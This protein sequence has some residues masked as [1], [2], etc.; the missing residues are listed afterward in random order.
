LTTGVTNLGDVKIE[1]HESK[2]HIWSVQPEWRSVIIWLLT[3]HENEVVSRNRYEVK[4]DSRGTAWFQSPPNVATASLVYAI[5]DGPD[6]I[7]DFRD[8]ETHGIEAN[9]PFTLT[10]REVWYS[11][12]D[13]RDTR[14]FNFHAG[15]Q[16]G[17]YDGSTERHTDTIN[18]QTGIHKVEPFGSW[19]WAIPAD[20]VNNKYTLVTYW[21]R[22]DGAVMGSVAIPITFNPKSEMA[23]ES[24]TSGLHSYLTSEANPKSISILS[25]IYQTGSSTEYEHTY[26]FADTKGLA[27]LIFELAKPEDLSSY[28]AVEFTIEFKGSLGKC[29]LGMRDSTSGNHAEA[30]C[31]EPFTPES[32]IKATVDAGQQ[33]L[34]IPLHNYSAIALTA[35]DQVY[36][37]IEPAVPGDAGTVKISNIRFIKQ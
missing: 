34:T 14:N 31:K 15:L 19:S 28:D 36:T 11:S 22:N 8:S 9:Q 33:T 7:L 18:V 16:H 20:F 35:I 3:M 12:N 10:L 23:L 30:P 17:A 25:G 37:D 4:L 26:S 1:T 27:G 32:G 29:F 5:N 24:I 2:A 13:Q 6:Q 21:I